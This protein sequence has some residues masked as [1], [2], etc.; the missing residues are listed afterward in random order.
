MTVNVSKK[1]N[2]EAFRFNHFC[3]GQAA[4]VKYSECE[5]IG[6]VIRHAKRMYQI[7]CHL[8]PVRLYNIYPDYRKNGK[9]F[10]KTLLKIQCFI[11]SPSKLQS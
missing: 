5:C 6:L 3:R 10:G 11:R 7:K 8:W 2:I 4:S 9:T 1:R